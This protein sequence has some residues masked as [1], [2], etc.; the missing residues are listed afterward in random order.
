MKNI[1]YFKEQYRFLSNFYL[2]SFAYDYRKW[3]SSE[4]A[5]Q[6]MKTTDPH[7][8]ETI[9][10]LPNAAATKKMGRK[11]KVR[12]DWD[13]VKNHFMYMILCC[14]FVQNLDLNEKLLATYPANLVEGNWWHDNYW[15]NCFCEK[16]KNTPG[17][18]ILGQTL[19]T[20]RGD[21]QK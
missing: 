2:A 9:R 7:I 16:C 21:W 20:I 13:E 18:N 3:P 1:L 14:K 15:G 8:Q 19:M 6:A 5:F 17:R 12:E 10:Q 4:H 11:I